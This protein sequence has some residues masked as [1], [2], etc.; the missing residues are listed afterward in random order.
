MDSILE[1]VL[2]VSPNRQYRGILIPTT[3][4]AQGPE[5]DRK[6]EVE[7]MESQSAVKWGKSVLRITI[8]NTSFYGDMAEGV[9]SE[10]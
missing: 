6:E 10:L 9:K 3:P 7:T 2:T 8:L 5:M 1:A 4:A